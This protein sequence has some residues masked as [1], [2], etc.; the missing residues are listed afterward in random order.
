V[1]LDRDHFSILDEL[2]RP[3]GALTG[4]MCELAETSPAPAP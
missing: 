1:A 2:E 3:D 4:L